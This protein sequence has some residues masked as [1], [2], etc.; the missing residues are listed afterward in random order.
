[1]GRMPPGEDQFP[2]ME[3]LNITINGIVKLLKDLNPY[4]SPGP[5]NIGPRVLKELADDVAPLLL[6][7]YRKSL[8]TGEVPDDWRSANV[9]PVYKKGQKYLPE[10]YRPISLTSICCKIME[11]IIASKIMTHG[12]DNNILYPLQ[13]GF[14]RGRSCETQLIEFVDDLSTN[15]EDG[16][17]T[18][19]LVMDFAKAFDK[20]CHSLLI[21]KLHHYGIQGKVNRWIQSWLTNRRQVVVVEGESSGSVSV[22]SGVPQGSVLGPGLFLYYINDLPSRLHSTTR[23]FADDTI[24]YLVIVTPEDARLLQEDLVSLEE[25]ERQWKMRFHPDK[26]TK[27]TVTRKKTQ[28]KAEYKLHDHIIASVSS[29]KYL[30]VTITDDLSWDTHIQNICNKANRTIG[31]LRR[32]LS[33]GAIA[34]KQQAYFSLVRP[35]VEYASTVWDPHTQVNIHRLEMVQRRAARYVT[36]RQRNKSSVGNMLHTLNW[37]TLQDRRKDARLCMMYKID[38]GLVAIRKDKRLVPHRRKTERLSHERAY[39]LIT[40]RTDRRKMSFF[41]RTVR[42]WNALPPGTANLETLEAF[43][44]QVS[45]QQH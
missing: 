1:S 15:L 37:R 10:N 33:I 13:H 22:E 6:L 38:R 23:L 27:L 21:H 34:I 26:C 7:I 9:T 16:Q 43:K 19:V 24:A 28:V 45:A 14:R 18:D 3:E 40:C 32:N 42:D 31:F 29:A 44:A 25:W 35:L 39:Q 5:D 4:K 20:V 41:P 12:E 8:D 17:Q 36:N 11:H 30:G 2:V